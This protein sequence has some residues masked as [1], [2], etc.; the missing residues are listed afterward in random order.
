LGASIYGIILYIC[1][2]KSPYGA[3]HIGAVEATSH[4]EDYEAV[5]PQCRV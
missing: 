3:D 2:K 4:W 5:S 1:K